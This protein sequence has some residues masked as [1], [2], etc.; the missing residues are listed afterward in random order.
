MV[1]FESF[2]AH[3]KGRLQ[4]PVWALPS[5]EAMLMRW[6]DW[7]ITMT[8]KGLNFVDVTNS[9]GESYPSYTG[10]TVPL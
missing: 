10:S 9:E 6:V 7:P 4:S 3:G 1:V 2:D 8:P 5:P